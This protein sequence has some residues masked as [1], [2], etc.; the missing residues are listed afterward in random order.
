MSPREI[1][2]P[3]YGELAAGETRKRSVLSL[4]RYNQRDNLTT[5]NCSYTYK[6]DQRGDGTSLD[7][8]YKATKT[9]RQ[10]SSM[11]QYRT[12][13]YMCNFSSKNPINPSFSREHAESP[14]A[15]PLDPSPCRVFPSA[16]PS[17]CHPHNR[18]FISSSHTIVGL[19]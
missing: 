2:A 7:H 17:S 12:A 19:P 3:R 15:S 5:T 10:N 18:I 8:I 1:N 16:D 4:S 9:I 14:S 6:R 11:I 13:T